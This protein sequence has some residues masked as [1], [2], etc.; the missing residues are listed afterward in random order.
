[1]AKCLKTIAIMQRKMKDYTL[2]YASIIDAVEIYDNDAS[3][4]DHDSERMDTKY[5]LALTLHAMGKFGKAI[6]VLQLVHRTSLQGSGGVESAHSASTLS[7]IANMHPVGV[8]VSVGSCA[9]HAEY[10][11][12]AIAAYQSIDQVRCPPPT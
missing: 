7:A 2:S 8:A 3:R 10:A 11:H 12:M 9:Q 5:T 4:P 1:V 6:E